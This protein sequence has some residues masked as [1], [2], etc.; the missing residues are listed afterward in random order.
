MKKL[1]VVVLAM[2]VIFSI[3]GLV[4]ES[5]ELQYTE[6]TEVYVRPG[7]TL[8]NIASSVNSDKYNNH[9]VIAEIK[10]LNKLDKVK[11]IPGQVLEIPQLE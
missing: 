9:Q 10:R 1:T 8:W 2:I 5:N 11:I 6:T 4:F 3:S 7:D